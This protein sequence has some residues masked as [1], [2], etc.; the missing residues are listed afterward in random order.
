MCFDIP[1]K[2]VTLIYLHS[3]LKKNLKD[4]K[5]ILKHEVQHRGQ[6]GFE[7]LIFDLNELFNFRLQVAIHKLYIVAP[8]TMFNVISPVFVYYY[9]KKRYVTVYILPILFWIYVISYLVK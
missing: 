7:S 9:R 3:S 1:D 4:R 6:N 8:F 5:E 2:D